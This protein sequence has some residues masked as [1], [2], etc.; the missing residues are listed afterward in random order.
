IALGEAGQFLEGGASSAAATGAG[1]DAGR[2][3]AQA[4]GLEEFAGGVD[5]FATIAAG[6]RGEGDANG[7]ADSLI[8]KDA[9]GGGGPDLA[10]HAHAGFG[11]AEVQRLLGFGAQVAIDGYQVAGARSFAGDDDLIVA[12][13]GLEGEFGGLER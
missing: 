8:K 3:G 5:L 12:Q 9:Q 4:E 7:V 10:L 6:T 2:E 13:A 1:S 11:K